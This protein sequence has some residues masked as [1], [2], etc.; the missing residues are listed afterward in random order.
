M[1][2]VLIVGAAVVISVGCSKVYVPNTPEGQACERECLLIYNTCVLR[3][4]CDSVCELGCT[5]Q[6]KNCR[7]TCPGAT[8]D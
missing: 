7:R 2:L 4:A 3:G 8:E 6:R 5:M 1:R